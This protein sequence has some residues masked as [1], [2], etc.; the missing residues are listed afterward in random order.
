MNNA[1]T[2]LNLAVTKGGFNTLNDIF[3][4]VMIVEKRRAHRH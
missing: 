4:R 2:A 3:R 1:I